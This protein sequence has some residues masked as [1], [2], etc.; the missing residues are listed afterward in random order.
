[1]DKS[2]NCRRGKKD[3]VAGNHIMKGRKL[4]DFGT[5]LLIAAVVFLVFRHLIEKELTIVDLLALPVI[6]ICMTYLGLPVS[7]EWHTFFEFLAVMIV[8]AAIGY[9]QAGK[10]NVEY[11]DEKITARGGLSYLIGWIAL[12]AGRLACLVVFHYPLLAVDFFP[13]LIGL[14]LATDW[15]MWL[16]GASA[17]VI[18]SITL[19][20]NVPEVN[21]YFN[22]QIRN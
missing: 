17:S 18:Y 20:M 9:R 8:G 14:L 22:E 11:R 19:Y 16:M 7:M 4:M 21:R 12:F 1:M 6:S 2:G 3:V 10:T 13:A 5:M 15:M